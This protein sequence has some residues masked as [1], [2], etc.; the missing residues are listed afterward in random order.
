LRIER[1]ISIGRPP[2]AVFTLL[3]DLE[4]L[5]EWA[6]IVVETREVSHRP[7]QE[8]C[9]FRQTVRVA[10]REI[11][12]EW[13]VVRF[14]SP[15]EVAYQ[16]TGPLGGRLSMTQRVRPDD[17]GSRVELEVDYEL[18]GGLIGSVAARVLEAE[19]EGAAEQSL[20]NLKEL[21]DG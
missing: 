14:E 12:T 11:D 20:V 1:E 15:R 5:P 19:N 17:G 18:P 7:L 4:R 8:G 10:G 16:A 3:T 2:D 13:R 6:T 9:T 21:L